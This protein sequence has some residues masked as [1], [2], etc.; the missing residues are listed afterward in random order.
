MVASFVVSVTTPTEAHAH[1]LAVMAVEGR[2]AACAQIAGPIRSIYWWEGTVTSASE[3]TCTFKTT[4][5]RLPALMAA[6]KE[7]HGYEVPEIVAVAIAD[8]D[9]AYLGWIATETQVQD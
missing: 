5:D 7:A 8:G 2:L 9:P 6:V 4:A 3:F 1:A